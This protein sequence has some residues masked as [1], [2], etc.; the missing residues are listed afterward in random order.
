MLGTPNKASQDNGAINSDPRNRCFCSQDANAVAPPE[1]HSISVTVNR[2]I[3]ITMP[4]MNMELEN[5]WHCSLGMRITIGTPTY[6]S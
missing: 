3:S 5:A 6:S 1:P 4:T 2:P